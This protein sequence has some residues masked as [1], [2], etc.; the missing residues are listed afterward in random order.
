MLFNKLNF[1]FPL[2][3]GGAPAETWW[4]ASGTN[5]VPFMRHKS[6]DVVADATITAPAGGRTYLYTTLWRAIAQDGLV[7]RLWLSV[8]TTGA[9]AWKAKVFRKNG[10]NYDFVSECAFTPSGTG[11]ISVDLSTPISCQPGDRIAIFVPENGAFSVDNTSANHTYNEA[12]GDIITTNAFTTQT[13]S[14]SMNLIP[15]GYQPFAV[16]IGD[17]IMEGHNTASVWHSVF[18]T[19][20]GPSGNP[21]AEVGNQMRAIMPGLEYQNY[22]FA[23]QGWVWVDATGLLQAYTSYALKASAWV[24]MAG[25][26]DISNGVTWDTVAGELATI[27]TRVVAGDLWICEI[28]PW[29]AG[30]DLQAATLRTWNDNLATWCAANNARLIACH[31][32]MGQVRVSTGEIDDLLTAYNQ[33]G[34]H[35][36]QAG[37]DALAAIIKA[38]LGA[39]YNP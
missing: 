2:G 20:N 6:S 14:K 1:S 37:V 3:S 13:T 7:R 25:V 18:D 31:D 28:L 9:T 8:I 22:A 29:T 12:D 4:L 27:R 39:V 23:D 11:L 17:S 5:L 26:N 35:L 36:K 24:I 19:A 34:V 15:Y 33:D 21:T 38:A 10:A 16:F 30:S 32:A